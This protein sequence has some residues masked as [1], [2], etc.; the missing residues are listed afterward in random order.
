VVEHLVD[1]RVALGPAVVGLGLFGGVGAQQIM[2]GEPA[3][4]LLGEQV[5]PRQLGQDGPGLAQ[6]QAR[7]AGRGRGADGGPGCS[8]SSRNIRAA[9]ASSCW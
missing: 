2:E 8:P 9:V 6:G 4:G 5:G 7:Q 1:G 3:G